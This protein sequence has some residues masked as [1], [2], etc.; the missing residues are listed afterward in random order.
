[1][2]IISN[3]LYCQIERWDDPGDYPN[4][5]ASGPL[6]SQHYGEFGGDLILEAENDEDMK[7][8]D[9]IEDWIDEYVSNLDCIS[10]YCTVSLNCKVEGNRAHVTIHDCEVEEYEPDEPDYDDRDD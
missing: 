3:D 4:G 10:R 1:M 7:E 2:K 9:A 6:P 8:L 5:L